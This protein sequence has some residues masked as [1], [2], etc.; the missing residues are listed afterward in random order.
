LDGGSESR[1]SFDEVTTREGDGDWGND[2]NGIEVSAD[3][4]GKGEAI[5]RE[6]ETGVK[7]QQATKSPPLRGEGG[8]STKCRALSS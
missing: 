8:T 4:Y 5:D 6:T 3:L 1:E 7:M 2:M